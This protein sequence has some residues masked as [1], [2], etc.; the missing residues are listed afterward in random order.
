[1]P[2]ETV[3]LPEGTTIRDNLDPFGAAGVDACRDVLQALG[4]WN[5]VASRGGLGA[6]MHADTLSQGQR[7]VFSLARAVLQRRMRAAGTA[8]A[9]GAACSSS[10]NS[11]AP[12]TA[13]RSGPC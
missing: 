6:M 5:F 12:S 1:M 9:G 7:Q 3:F 13:R 4:L 10:T 2:Q 11:A 8:A